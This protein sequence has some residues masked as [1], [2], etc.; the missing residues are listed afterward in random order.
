MRVLGQEKYKKENARKTVYIDRTWQWNQTHYIDRIWQW[1]KIGIHRHT[2]IM[3]RDHGRADYLAVLRFNLVD[4]HKA[5]KNP[6]NTQSC[7]T[8]AL[9]FFPKH[10]VK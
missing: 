8:L 2:M 1:N 7:I 5:A 4:G 6:E 10:T 9:H 3:F